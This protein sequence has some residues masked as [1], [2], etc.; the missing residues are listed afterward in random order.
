MTI[1]SQK[2]ALK[3]AK[4]EHKESAKTNPAG[5]YAERRRLAEQIVTTPLPKWG[6]ARVTIM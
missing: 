6:A 3:K 4:Q 2:E 1:L 5:F